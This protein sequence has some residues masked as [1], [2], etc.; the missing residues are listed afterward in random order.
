MTARRI[1]PWL[2]LLFVTAL[3]SGPAHASCAGPELS[4]SR[5]RA[6]AGGTVTVTG[7]YLF[8]GCD[9][10]G[11]GCSGQPDPSHPQ[12]PLTLEIVAPAGSVPLGEFN[13]DET[14]ARRKQVV[15]P[16]D[17]RGQVTLRLLTHRGDEYVATQL[18][19]L[20]PPRPTTAPPT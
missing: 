8:D 17:L 20:A 6:V 14:G 9:D 10:T 18:L 7:R 16:A 3:L 19:V 11:G 12:R 4:V 13:P 1:Q 2:S 15:L 5:A